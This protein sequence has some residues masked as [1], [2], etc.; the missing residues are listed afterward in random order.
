[1][2]IVEDDSHLVG[3]DINNNSAN[4]QDYGRSYRTVQRHKLECSHGRLSGCRR[5]GQIKP[6]N[7]QESQEHTPLRV[8]SE[9]SQ[10]SLQF[11]YCLPILC[12]IY[13]TKQRGSIV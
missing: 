1:M 10:T 2:A 8:S 11:G 13:N 3:V 7:N 9:P 5:C 12:I 4:W 6:G